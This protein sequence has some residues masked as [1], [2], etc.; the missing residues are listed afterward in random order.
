MGGGR[1]TSLAKVLVNK[2]TLVSEVRVTTVPIP[3]SRE[4][5]WRERCITCGS[6]CK[7][8]ESLSLG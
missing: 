4:G 3:K 5:G 2:G 8:Q 1:G 7:V 6:M